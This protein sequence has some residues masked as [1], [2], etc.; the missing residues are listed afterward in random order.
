MGPQKADTF[1]AM[2]RKRRKDAGKRSVFVAQL[3]KLV[4]ITS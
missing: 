3:D 4:R 2:E 1:Q